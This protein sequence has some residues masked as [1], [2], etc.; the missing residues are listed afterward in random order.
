MD[1]GTS[2]TGEWLAVVNLLNKFSTDP[3]FLSEIGLEDLPPEKVVEGLTS[4]FGFILAMYNA[5]RKIFPTSSNLSI[6]ELFVKLIYSRLIL[7]SLQPQIDELAHLDM[8]NPKDA[9]NRQKLMLEIRVAQC[10]LV[11]DVLEKANKCLKEIK[12]AA[13]PS[14][15]WDDLPLSSKFF[16]ICLALFI[17]EDQ[18]DANRLPE[19]NGK[20]KA[21]IFVNSEFYSSGARTVLATAFKAVFSQ[22]D[23]SL[24]D[25]DTQKD[26]G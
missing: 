8:D 24:E 3:S 18:Y 19:E 11:P 10:D 5:A 13:H 9:E 23:W 16:E 1:S 14:P 21:T 6:D 7:F 2:K 25:I 22:I 26:E 4:V 15:E 12:G 20:I 17:K